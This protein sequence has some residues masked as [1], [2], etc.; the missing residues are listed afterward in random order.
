MTYKRL[1]EVLGGSANTANLGRKQESL[2]YQVRAL[3]LRKTLVTEWPDDLE[4]KNLLAQTYHSIGEWY[5]NAA[6]LP[7]AIENAQGALAMRR[8]LVA[9]DE[10]N[11]QFRRELAIGISSNGTL[12]LTN[13]DAAGALTLYQEALPIYEVLARDDSG[14]PEREARSR[15]GMAR[16]GYGALPDRS[17]GSRAALLRPRLSAAAGVHRGG[18]DELL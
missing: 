16:R 2:Q 3:E 1:G 10:L 6:D 8:Q 12:L 18:T 9:A 17:A 7:H 14:Q 15:A 5:Y 13:G 11:Q 4:Y